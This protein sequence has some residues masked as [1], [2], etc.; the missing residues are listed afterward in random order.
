MSKVTRKFSHLPESLGIWHTAK[1]TVFNKRNKVCSRSLTTCVDLRKSENMSNGKHLATGAPLPT[2]QDDGKIRLYSM[3]FCPYAQR[4]HLVLDAKDIPYHTIYVNLQAK[5]E[6][7]YDRSP[8]GTVPAV[9]LPNESGGASLYESL[10]ISDYLDEKFPQRPLYPRTPLAKAKERLLIKKFDTVIDVMYKVF[11]GE[12]VPG[13][14]TEIS[15]R[16]DFFEKEL[17]T[18]GSDFFGGNV[19]G[20]VDYMIWPWCERADMLTYLLGDKYVLDEERFPKLVKWRALM[21]EDKAVKGSYLSGEVHAKYMEGRRQG[22]AD[23]DM[24]V[25]IAK[26]QRTS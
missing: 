9:D 22:N 21:K 12:H 1:T 4:V 26:K 16:L 25:N 20:M 8:P 15:N 24:L 7:L 6:W 10:V 14:L 11:L 17:Q 5:P 18:R 13:T 2:L 23:Y 19:P 3:R